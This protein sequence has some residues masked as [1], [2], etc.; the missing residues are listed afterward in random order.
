M[1]KD[2]NID[3]VILGHSERRTIFKETDEFIAQKAL[4]AIQNGT[5]VMFCIGETLQE[6][7]AGE[8]TNV[9]FRQLEA[10][11]AVL[12]EDE[13]SQVVLAYEPVWAIGTGKVAT[14]QQVASFSH[15]LFSLTIQAQDVHAAIRG[16]MKEKVSTAVSEATRIM[17]GGSVNAKNCGELQSNPDVDGF[18]V[19]GASL[20]G[21]DFLTICQCTA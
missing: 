7:E 21:A 6:R 18:L 10:L 1:L 16:W 15:L 12:K 3:W 19:G 17:Y 9:C 14:P 13:W 20:K 4:K 11:R 5:K 8:T 2:L